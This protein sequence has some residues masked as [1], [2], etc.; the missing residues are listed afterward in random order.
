VSLYGR[1]VARNYDR[2]Y[3][4]AERAGLSDMRADLLLSLEG[5]VLEVGGGTGLNLAHIPTSVSELVIVEPDELMIRRLRPRLAGAPI[6][7]RIVRSDAERL[8]FGDG[9]F[10]AAVCTFVLCTVRDLDRSLAEVRRV[11]RPG[12]RLAFL[13]HVESDDPRLARLQDRMHGAWLKVGHGCH[14]NRR[15]LDALQASGFQV[16]D[17]ERGDLPKAPPFFR[18]YVSGIARAP[19]GKQQPEAPPI[20]VLAGNGKPGSG[21]IFEWNP[22]EGR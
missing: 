9:T 15:T 3:A 19:S 2:W 22:Q 12:G 17:V 21:K 20:R 7:T 18:P 4:P 5:R 1:F 10:D 16:A 14:L 8:P 11:L 6:A 13:E